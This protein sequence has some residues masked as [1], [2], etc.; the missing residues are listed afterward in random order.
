[1]TVESCPLLRGFGKRFGWFVGIIAQ[2]EPLVPLV[3]CKCV[4]A[5]TRDDSMRVAKRFRAESLHGDNDWLLWEHV[6]VVVEQAEHGPDLGLNVDKMVHALKSPYVFNA[7]TMP[8][9]V[10]AVVPVLPV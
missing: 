7:A 6:S 9:I 3:V 1:M 10:Y 5:R 2:R 8:L 4:I